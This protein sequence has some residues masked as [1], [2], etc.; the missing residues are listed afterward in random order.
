MNVHPNPSILKY[1]IKL[2]ALIMVL[3]FRLNIITGIRFSIILDKC[4]RY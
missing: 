2:I 3:L 1:S 4:M